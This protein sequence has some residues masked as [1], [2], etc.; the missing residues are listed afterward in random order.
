MTAIEYPRFVPVGDAA[1]LVEFGSETTDEIVAAVASLDAALAAAPPPGFR[2]AVPALVNLLVDFDPL[3]TD[4]PTI[5]ATARALVTRDHLVE[6]AVSE[7]VVRVCYDSG[8]GPD[9][10]AVAD[11]CAMSVDAVIAAHL[12]G[13]YRVAMYGFAPGYAYLTG[14]DPSIQVPRKPAAV[15]D[16]AADSVIIAGPQ[17]IVTTLTMPTGWSIIGR[18]VTPIL[19]FDDDDRAFLFDVGDRVRFERI[20]LATYDQT[21]AR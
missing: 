7:R 3:V 2:E 1:L 19:S 18:S 12:A 5:E 11:A 16:V 10:A 6:R 20:D 15:R 8:L 17:C 4:H 9:L 14:V 21:A 13:D